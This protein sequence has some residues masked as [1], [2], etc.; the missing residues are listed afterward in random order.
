MME[1]WPRSARSPSAVTPA[2]VVVAVVAVGAALL[3]TLWLRQWSPHTQFLLFHFAV[4]VS[5]LAGGFLLGALATAASILL[6]ELFLFGVPGSLELSGPLLL[7]TFVLGGISLT[8]AWLV[9][10]LQRSRAR[11]EQARRVAE[12]LNAAL[13]EQ[14]E[15]LELQVTESEA[16][17]AELEELNE[18]LNDQTGSAQR[19]AARAERLQR[20]A[21][22]LLEAAGEAAVQRIAARGVKRAVE[23]A[24]AAII[25]PDE[26]GEL[27]VAACETA[28]PALAAVIDEIF[29]R[30]PIALDVLRDGTPAW[31]DDPGQLA[32]VHPAA[33]ALPAAARSW[34][35]LPLHGQRGPLA[36]LVLAFTGQSRHPAEDRSFLEM[37]AQQCAQALER[38][39]LHE[40]GLRGRVRAE[41]A[42]RRLAFLAEASARLASA[43]DYETTLAAL[44]RMCVPDFADWCMVHLQDDSGLARLVAVAHSDPQQVARRRA[45][46]ERSPGSAPGIPF[47]RIVESGTAEHFAELPDELLRSAAADE[48]Q[49]EALRSFGIRAQLSVPISVEE[50]VYGTLTLAFEAAD[51]RFDPPDETLA[52]ELGRRAGHAVENAK[53]YAAAHFASEA[54]SDFLAVMSHE[55]RTPLNAIIGY[56]DLL[57][58]GVPTELPEKPRRQVERIRSASDSLLHLVEEVLSFSRIEAGKEELRISPVNLTVLLQ[59]AAAMIEPLAAEKSLQVVLDLPEE[60]L[61][62]VSDERKIRQIATNLLSNAVKFTDAGAIR[63][64]AT[65]SDSDIGLHFQDTGIGIAPEHLDRIFEPFWQVEQA[66]TRRFG[67]TGL[68]LGVARKLATLLEGRLDVSSGIGQ[69][70]TFTLTLPRRTPG[71]QRP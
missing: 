57:L 51:R 44:A 66:T 69:G 21:A 20:L 62:L 25:L 2:S 68:G 61:K 41:F 48:A 64:A 34:A 28:A 11:A 38:A 49:L 50:R 47:D 40:S 42:E 22:L 14:A 8:A 36:V 53:L 54:K 19:A 35:A 33:S 43:L 60:P 5:A 63:I 58:L 39:Y 23:A 59:E 52:L 9:S 70:S 13:R 7:R 46:E 15:E 16:M 10:A 30:G 71:M 4:I 55:L 12:Q 32:D 26:S 37:A 56:S 65:A 18:Q 31:F 67:G 29:C 17:A 3:L 45:L 27:R 6:V 24:A 1:W